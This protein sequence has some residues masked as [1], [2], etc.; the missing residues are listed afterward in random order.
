MIGPFGESSGQIMFDAGI[1]FIY[2]QSVHFSVSEMGELECTAFWILVAHFCPLLFL[3][4]L[5]KS[6]LLEEVEIENN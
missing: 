2:V 4:K 3:T 5:S 6:Y 1:A